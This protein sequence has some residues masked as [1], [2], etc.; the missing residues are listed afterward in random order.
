MD[1]SLRPR[2]VTAGALCAVLSFS[3]AA[4]TSGSPDFESADGRFVNAGGPVEIDAGFT[5]LQESGPTANRIDFVFFGDRYRSGQVNCPGETFTSANAWRE[6]KPQYSCYNQVIPRVISHMRSAR[7][8]ERYL[9]V[10]NVYRDD[11]HLEQDVDDP[12]QDVD[13][14][15]LQAQH[16]LRYSE[17]AGEVAPYDYAQ[18]LLNELISLPRGFTEVTFR[19]RGNWTYVHPWYA[20]PGRAPYTMHEP[21][22]S[23]YSFGDG[24]GPTYNNNTG[25]PREPEWWYWLGFDQKAADG[26]QTDVEG[27][28]IIG[29]YEGCRGTW[30]A[31]PWS[32]MTGM[33]E[34]QYPAFN[35]VEREAII[36]DFFSRIRPLDG[37][38]PNDRRLVDPGWLWVRTLSDD[39][40]KVEWLVDGRRTGRHGPYLEVS[41]LDL[42]PGA[43]VIEAHAYDEVVEHAYSDRSGRTAYSPV[44]A[45]PHP[46]DMVRMHRDRLQ[47]RVS[48]QVQLTGSTAGRAPMELEVVPASFRVRSSAANGREVGFVLASGL[49]GHGVTFGLQEDAGGRFAIHERSGRVVVA[50]S[51]RLDPG[52][53]YALEVTAAAGGQSRSAPVTVRV[54]DDRALVLDDGFDDGN[55]TTNLRG[56]GDGWFRYVEPGEQLHVGA[57]LAETGG[58]LRIAADRE[59]GR[60][61]PGQRGEDAPF[62][63]TAQVFSREHFD[64]DSKQGVLITVDMAQSP[65]ALVNGAVPSEQRNIHIGR[66]GAS[67]YV[68]AVNTLTAGVYLLGGPGGKPAVC[69]HGLDAGPRCL[70]SWQWEKDFPGLWDLTSAARVEWQV[71]NEGYELRVN[72]TT[73]SAQQW[74]YGFMQ[75]WR[76]SDGTPEFAE[77]MLE[78]RASGSRR[79]GVLDPEQAWNIDRVRVTRADMLQPVAQPASP[80]RIRGGS[81]DVARLPE[82]C[83]DSGGAYFGSLD[84]VIEI[85]PGREMRLALRDLVPARHGTPGA[86]DV[87][88]LPPG[89]EVD[90]TSGVIRGTPDEQGETV[91]GIAAVSE[92]GNYW[93]VFTFRVAG[94]EAASTAKSSIGPTG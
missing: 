68:R 94:Q 12:L 13:L 77:L 63:W 3:F 72:G 29:A 2:A 71:S 93:I 70:D 67:G 32:I 1:R 58:R 81:V 69:L 55:W 54:L 44:D 52:R 47:Q 41:T 66:G 11:R 50:E 79:A 80:G 56:V 31:Q 42:E 30:R 8:Y 74:P 82:E 48:W 9:P 7:V 22:H 25:Y 4:A 92:R 33:A 73:V 26:R 86:F 88:P 35:A 78:S 57:T 65:V 75:K 38:K 10:F 18:G 87:S 24:C 14:L 84:C 51:S 23:Y 90:E 46:L 28:Y 53:T 59:T 39:L 83:R 20:N 40:V 34:L 5:I 62:S 64:I 19:H 21:A 60:N 85:E 45:S 49:P 6:G 37:W 91:M 16:S 15:A 36:L 76:V 17:R 89:L 27:D 61:V 43:H